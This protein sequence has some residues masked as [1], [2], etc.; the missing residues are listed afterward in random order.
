MIFDIKMEDFCC[1]ACLVAGGHM[2]K[3]FTHASVVICKI[4]HIALMLA[5]L[6]SLDVMTVDIMNTY[7]TV[8]CKEK[9]WTTLGSEFSKDKGKKAS[10]VKALYGLKS[11]GH[12]FQEHLADYMHSLGYKSCLADP[13]LWY[14]AFTIKGNNGNIKSYYLCVLVYEDNIICIYKDPDSVLKS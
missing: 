8:M 7:I 4:V 10:I 5:A 6:N 2:T 9:I 12:A 3:V 11:A 13:D 1:K 14:K